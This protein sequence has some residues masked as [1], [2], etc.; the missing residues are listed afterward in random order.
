MGFLLRAAGSR[1]LVCGL[2]LAAGLLVAGDISPG[3]AQPMERMGDGRGH[4]PVP[5]HGRSG[6]GAGGSILR[7]VGTGLA[8]G[9]VG[10]AIEGMSKPPAPAT[11]S[12]P[13]TKPR[14]K[15][16]AKPQP[17][18]GKSDKPKPSTRKK[19]AAPPAPPADGPKEK[20]PA[21]PAE[22]APPPGSEAPP[23]V[24]PENTAQSQDEPCEECFDLWNR[25]RRYQDL[26]TREQ[27]ELEDLERTKARGEAESKDFRARAA[28]ASGRI[29]GDYDN[30][31]ADLA[32]QFVNERGELIESWKA[33]IASERAFLEDLLV[34]FR[35][36]VERFC[37]KLAAAPEPPPEPIPEPAPVEPVAATPAPSASAPFCPANANAAPVA[38]KLVH[39][40]GANRAGPPTPTDR[41]F[42]LGTIPEEV[43][44]FALFSFYN[45][46]QGR[47]SVADLVKDPLKPQPA[48]A[49]P[50][51]VPT[52]AVIIEGEVLDTI[53]QQSE[54]INQNNWAKFH[55]QQNADDMFGRLRCGQSGLFTN[56]GGQIVKGDP[57]ATR[58]H[59]GFGSFSVYW[60]AVCEIGPKRCCIPDSDCESGW[61]NETLYHCKVKW[62][63]YDTYN[64]SHKSGTGGT[65][66]LKRINPLGWGG[67]P[68]QSFGYWD[69]VAG[70]VLRQC[71]GQ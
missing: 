2:C 29:E 65:G 38:Q 18:S 15:P 33:R 46:G 34:Q 26:I 8:I 17:K 47:T 51:G 61:R 39:D 3:Q 62:T 32:D 24:T 16:K 59:L 37:A 53:Q 5:H 9:I 20:P 4:S 1:V 67:T 13:A 45:G 35:Q 42:R 55:L 50:S 22:A 68:F 43:A 31:M 70:G 21:R 71:V 36:C 27:R 63:M 23:P 54:V 11:S 6:G 10:G 58:V 25:I 44:W 66:L 60:D 56:R 48:D 19:Q 40:Y 14:A 64:F 57:A 52:D 28:Q 30:R 49:M 12:Q 41:I 69:D 7:D